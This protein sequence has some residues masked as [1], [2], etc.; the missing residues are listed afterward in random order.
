MS[1]PLRSGHSA[2]HRSPD[3]V[4]R[5]HRDPNARC[6]S[7]FLSSRGHGRAGASLRRRRG[8]AGPS[9]RY[10]GETHRGW[11][12]SLSRDDTRAAIPPPSRMRFASGGDQPGTKVQ[13]RR[14]KDRATFGPTAVLA[15]SGIESRA[16]S[17]YLNARLATKDT[18]TASEGGSPMCPLT[19]RWT[20]KG[21]H[22]LVRSGEPNESI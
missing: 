9:R 17:N 4:Q 15:A 14:R 5:R 19:D 13:G 1:P 11:A 21:S 16:R 20:L 6:A 22:P 8:R 2:W 3:R 12:T 7:H 18:A 10:G